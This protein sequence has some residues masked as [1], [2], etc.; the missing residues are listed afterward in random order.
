MV[1]SLLRRI[2]AGPKP[3]TATI[4]TVPLNAAKPRRQGVDFDISTF[5]KGDRVILHGKRS[6]IT[7]PLRLNGKTKLNRGFIPHSDIIEKQARDAVRSNHGQSSYPA[8]PATHLRETAS[9]LQGLTDQADAVYRLSYPTLDQYATLTPRLVT[10]VYPADASL[11]VSLLDIHVSPPSDT[12]SIPDEP[13][14]ILEAGTGHG[15][16]T[17][18]LARAISAA[19]T[20]PPHLPPRQTPDHKTKKTELPEPD[21][22]SGLRPE[23][24]EEV[25]QWRARRK[26]I[27][28]T[29]DISPAYSTHAETIVRGFRRG[30]YA[31]NVD[32]YTSPVE[33]WI[34]EQTQRRRRHLQSPN[35][36]E[37]EGEAKPF[38]QYAILDM[39]AAHER[40]PHVSRVLKVDGTLAVFMPSV[41]QIGECVQLVN[42]LRL[43]LMLERAVEL[44]TGISSG[45]TWDVRTASVRRQTSLAV[46]AQEGEDGE[47][48]AREPEIA[49]DGEEASTAEKTEEAQPEKRTVL[50]CRPKVGDKIVGGG[51]VGIW[52]KIKL[53]D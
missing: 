43:P 18:H 3:T 29:V 52:R 28:H 35:D 7:S 34:E 21:P 17:L 50:V 12:D 40:I 44:G 6:V 38:L 10:P 9:Q 8:G 42:E 26:A 47:D 19:N 2:V 1:L 11:I 20:A 27:V 36:Q 23:Q 41:T 24:E 13:L 53:G 30:M 31:G 14:E 25:K 39:P 46:A 16:L 15:S 51:F 33:Q 49:T 48:A 45:R 4:P 22:E 37:A 32:F 5:K